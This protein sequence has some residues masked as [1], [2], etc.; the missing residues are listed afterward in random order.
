L[1]E[2][3]VVL[4]GPSLA[5]VVAAASIRLRVRDPRAV[6]AVNDG[7]RTT[8]SRSLARVEGAG[9]LPSGALSNSVHDGEL[10]TVLPVTVVVAAESV[11]ASRGH[12]S[13]E[14]LTTST[15]SIALREGDANRGEAGAS[16]VGDGVGGRSS[17]LNTDL[18][19]R[20][21]GDEG[22]NVLSDS[23]VDVSGQALARGD[24]DNTGEEDA[25]SAEAGSG[26][27]RL[28]DDVALATVSVNAPVGVGNEVALAE[29]LG[30]LAVKDA[31]TSGVV[32][33]RGDVGAESATVQPDTARVVNVLVVP[34]ALDGVAAD[35]R[36]NVVGE[37]VNVVNTMIL[38]LEDVV[39]LRGVVGVAV[40]SA[41]VLVEV[42]VPVVIGELVTV[43][44]GLT[45]ELTIVK[46]S[47]SEVALV[48][49]GVALGLFATSA[50]TTRTT[51]EQV[52][53]LA[54]VPRVV[55]AIEPA[56]VAL[57]RAET[58]DALEVLRALNNSGSIS[59]GSNVSVGTRQ[60]AEDLAV[61]A[62]TNVVRVPR[63]ADIPIDDV[64]VAIVVGLDTNRAHIRTLE[65]DRSTE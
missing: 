27:A 60:Q 38:D 6:E 50:S 49:S 29:T 7:G 55:V 14:L 28:G 4:L 8:I 24:G 43:A 53:L 15:T 31:A 19:L 33:I 63:C 25:R 62:S 2:V 32:G 64:V 30:L 47:A 57:E 23:T 17:R 20:P 5:T 58:R 40:S 56:G 10:A 16:T 51:A 12:L 59:V 11:V 37:D 45:V 9:G 36:I 52:R 44:E 3:N 18:T 65:G 54:A 42:D 39:V 46:G 26:A 13:A 35:Q 22:A 61:E 21:V 34:V 1:S 48:D 41:D